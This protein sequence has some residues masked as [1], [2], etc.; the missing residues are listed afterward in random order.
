MLTVISFLFCIVLVATIT[1]RKLK[2]QKNNSKDS[3]FLGGR[4]LTGGVIGASL[5]LT[6]LSASNFVGMSAQAY[7][8]NMSVM[9]WE[10]GSGITLVIVA[11]FL[12]PRY[13]K[14]GVTTV[15]DFLEE[16]FDS[17][18]KKIVSILFLLGYVSN[19]L[20]ITLY[21]GAIALAQIFN[22]QEMFGISYTASIWIMV[23]VIG[24]IGFIYAI[25]GGLKAV[26]V[27]DTLNGIGLAIGGLI[28]PIF[29]IIYFG[30]GS[31]ST[32]LSNILVN[33]SDK[34]NAIG[35]SQDPIP[36]GTLFTGMLLVNLYYWGTDQAII[37][38]ALAAKNLAEGQKG[39]IFA[40]LLKVLTPLIVIVPGIV[41][42]HIYGAGVENPDL[43]YSR[44]V[45]DVLPKPLIGFFAAAMFGSVLSVFNGVLNSAST[46]FALNVYSP[47]FGK[48]KSDKEIISKGKIFGLVLAIISMTIAPFIMYAPQG[49]FQYLQTVNGFFNV[50]IFTI[51]FIGYVTKKVPAIAAKI[52]I[53]FFVLTYGTLQLIIK[54][55]MHF[56]HQLGI[57]FVITCMIMLIIGKI[58]PREKEY[59][60]KDNKVVDI[61]P[62]KYR[63]E[64]CGVVLFLMVSMYVVCSRLGFASGNGIGIR[65]LV[66]IAVIAV[67]M[68][69]LVKVVKTRG[70]R[71][72]A[73]D[74]AELVYRNSVE[75]LDF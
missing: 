5:L 48:G 49:L 31:F 19:L 64:A 67:V 74:N 8:S 30:H 71:K 70:L 12:L 60:L 75:K 59:V 14:Q 13:L 35:T 28:V 20:P 22:V 55:E 69:G 26:A 16:R 72:K 17:G 73:G 53:I 66:P 34:F 51:V 44:L 33:H 54:P 68:Y 21:S 10:V 47:V 57:L 9:G 23:W 37:Q 32:G 24:I 2:G 25:L 11:L 29:G 3:Y 62:W 6:N 36:F 43:L 18:V 63:Y 50:P 1:Y 39:I 38:R 45:N 7:S 58:K 41:A 46:L 4:S 61:K 27:S 42:F 40:G 52:S 65:T 15:P 56:L